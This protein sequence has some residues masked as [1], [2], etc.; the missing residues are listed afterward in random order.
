MPEVFLAASPLVATPKIPAT[1]EKKPLVPRVAFSTSRDQTPL[2]S[3]FFRFNGLLRSQLQGLVFA[4]E[5]LLNC[6]ISVFDIVL[7][8]QCAFIGIS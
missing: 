2:K 5:T 7:L 8:F 1:R 4:S 3:E 6:E